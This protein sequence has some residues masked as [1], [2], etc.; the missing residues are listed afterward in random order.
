MARR[1]RRRRESIGQ[2]LRA[3][4]EFL[5]RMGRRGRRKFAHRAGRRGRHV[6]RGVRDAREVGAPA[7][8]RRDAGRTRA[9]G[10]RGRRALG[11]EARIRTR[12]RMP[13]RVRNRLW[14]MT[15]FSSYVRVYHS[16]FWLA[17]A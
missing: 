9:H 6:F 16:G 17:M 1:P 11:G 12:R 7:A 4:R 14:V 13:R 15:V 5:E 3:K 10:A 8:G 2:R